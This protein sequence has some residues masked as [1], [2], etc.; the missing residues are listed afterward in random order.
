M[1]KIKWMIV[2]GYLVFFNRRTPKLMQ[3]RLDSSYFAYLWNQL[4]ILAFTGKKD[5][6]TKEI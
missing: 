3:M 4:D 6:V 2:T 5:G 1:K